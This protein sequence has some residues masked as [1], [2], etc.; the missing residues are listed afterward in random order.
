MNRLTLTSAMQLCGPDGGMAGERVRR[1]E[2][3]VVPAPERATTPARKSMNASS[4]QSSDGLDT[5]I[6]AEAVL[7][8]PR[9]AYGR[10]TGDA[11]GFNDAWRDRNP[12]YEIAVP[13]LRELL[14]DNDPSVSAEALVALENLAGKG[15]PPAELKSL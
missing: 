12:D 13:D 11:A 6:F 14:N 8:A 2:E 15:A 4:E 9:D 5:A 1:R 10:L 3:V 7:Y